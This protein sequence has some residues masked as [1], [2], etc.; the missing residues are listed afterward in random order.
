MRILIIKTSSFGDIIHALPVLHW[1]HK[2]YPHALVDWLVEKHLSEIPKKHPL[3]HQTLMVSTLDL[4]K[5]P[6][7]NKSWQEFWHNIRL[8]KRTEYDYVFDLQGNCKSGF[9]TFLSRAKVKVGFD[10]RTAREWPNIFA[11]HK[12]F[13]VSKKQNVRMQNLSLLQ[14][15]FQKSVSFHSDGVRLLLEENEREKLKE[16]LNKVSAGDRKKFMVCPGT[17]WEN[18]RLSSSTWL[19]FLQK[20]EAKEEVTFL[21]VWG[22]NEEKRICDELQQGLKNAF[23]LEER[24]SISTWQSL[25]NEMDLVLGVDSSAVHLSGTTRARSFSV[26]GPTKS[27]I[28]KPLGEKH[29]AFQGICPYKQAF[30]KTC[31]LLRTCKTGACLKEIDLDK[32]YEAFSSWFYQRL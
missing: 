27:S 17:K 10:I 30:Q 9:L 28:F 11:S 16:I 21:L 18:K 4:K 19:Q 7:K 5:A 8:L 13:Y 23:V 20:I 31:P 2:T 15:F 25:M 3:V 26:F 32:L 22:T 12:R 6:F 1:I 14:L 24:L 29:F